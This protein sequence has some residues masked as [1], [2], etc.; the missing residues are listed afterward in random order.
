[1]AR[2]TVGNSSVRTARVFIFGVGRMTRL[3]TFDAG[4]GEACCARDVTVVCSNHYLASI[5][6]HE[7]EYTV[8]S[9]WPLGRASLL[10]DA[11]KSGQCCV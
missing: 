6:E 3:A 2:V 9:L 4:L 8:Q 11:I 1:M 10:M 5:K 7:R